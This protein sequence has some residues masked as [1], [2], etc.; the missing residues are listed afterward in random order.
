MFNIYFIRNWNICFLYYPCGF[1]AFCAPRS[2]RWLSYSRIVLVSAPYG[3]IIAN[4]TSILRC[5]SSIRVPVNFIILIFPALIFT[6]N[7][8]PSRYNLFN[9]FCNYPVVRATYPVTNNTGI[10]VHRVFRD[11]LRVYIWN[12]LGES[13]HPCI[14]PLVV[15]HFFNLGDLSFTRT[16]P[17]CS[18]Y[19][20]FFYYY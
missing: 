15:G 11:F 3:N 7:F 19:V 4:T 14:N 9:I 16:F 20:F 10:R 17:V 13:G 18:Q 6:P 5:K 1:S 8:F 2:L 12:S